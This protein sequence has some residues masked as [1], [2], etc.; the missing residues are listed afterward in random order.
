TVARPTRGDGRHGAARPGQSPDR[1]SG[2]RPAPAAR[3]ATL[4]PARA[5]PG[6]ALQPIPATAVDCRLSERATARAGARGA[7]GPAGAAGG[8]A[9]RRSTTAGDRP[10]V[11]MPTRG[12]GAPLGG[13]PAREP[14]LPIAPHP[15]GPPVSGESGSPAHDRSG[16]LGRLLHLDPVMLRTS[17]QVHTCRRRVRHRHRGGVDAGV[18][19]GPPPRRE[20]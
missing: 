20:G 3:A 16:L 17:P 9:L 10:P 12:T 4:T 19:A 14:P 2:S 11:H 18:T 7:R 15:S 5:V 6:R 13:G 1:L 8:G